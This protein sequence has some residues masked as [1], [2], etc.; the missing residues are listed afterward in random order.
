[1]S[2]ARI[3]RLVPAPGYPSR[4]V[5]ISMA[6]LEELHERIVLAAMPLSPGQLAWQPRPG[7][8]TPGMLL[9]HIAVA[10]THL[11]QVGLLGETAGH[12]QDVIGIREDDDGMPLD[13]DGLPPAILRDKDAAWFAGLLAR[14]L[15]N[16]RTAAAQLTDEDLDH[17]VVRPPRPD[18]TQRIFN[19]RWALWHIVEHT[20]GHLGQLQMLANLVRG[21]AG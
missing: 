15:A 4:E 13:P 3:D 14:S 6:Q 12:V 16:L 18:G 11:T 2:R 19:K 8:S 10:E 9:A 1:M 5:A 21:Q 20:S 7:A 17:D